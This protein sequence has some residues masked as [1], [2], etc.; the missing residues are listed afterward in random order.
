MTKVIDDVNVLEVTTSIVSEVHAVSRV[1]ARR[2]PKGGMNLQR[3]HSFQIQVQVPVLRDLVSTIVVKSV[4]SA[5]VGRR[6][7]AD[8]QGRR[9]DEKSLSPF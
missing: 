4:D 7:A 9:S 6:L 3:F 5:S 1:A 2:S 8:N